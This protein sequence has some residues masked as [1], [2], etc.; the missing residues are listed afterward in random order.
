MYF[1]KNRIKTGFN[2]NGDLLIKSTNKPYFGPYFETSKGKYYAGNTPDYANLV[3]LIQQTKVPP[4]EFS[5]D[6]GFGDP[7]FNYGNN[8][9][10]STNQ[11]I[12]EFSTPQPL[13]PKYYNSKPTNEQYRQ[14]EY[15]RYF[16][17]KTNEYIYIEIDKKT[18]YKLKS[19]DPTILWTL[20]DCLY[21][22]YSLRSNEVNRKLALQIEK[23]N[24]WYGFLSYLNLNLN[25]DLD[26]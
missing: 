5:E 21:M 7:R 20:Y 16:A 9:T 14:G 8:L 18:Y 15:I 10:Y 24:Q 25:T 26:T 1:P 4:A 3:E 22:I 12:E 19:E 23:Q 11:G 13:P 6:S 2:S 17:K